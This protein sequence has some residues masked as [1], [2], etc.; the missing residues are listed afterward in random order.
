MTPT[1]TNLLGLVKHLSMGEAVYFGATFGRPF[2]EKLTWW[3]DDAEPNI[4]CWVTED[5]TRE[6]VLDRYHRAIAQADATIEALPLD[7]P[8]HVPWWTNPETSLHAVLVHVVA[9]SQR[10]AGHADIL[11]EGL[12]GSAG[13]TPDFS[14]LPDG[15]AAWWSDYCARVERAARAAQEKWD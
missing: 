9:E 8:G 1:G 4:D 15:D 13:I 7:A 11:R 2:P 14:N 3:D 6:E 5:E 10:H 12:D